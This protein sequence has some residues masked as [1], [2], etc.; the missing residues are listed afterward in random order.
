M[1]NFFKISIVSIFVIT[2]LLLS[3]VSYAAVVELDDFNLSVD[4]LLGFNDIHI[5]DSWDVVEKNCENIDPPVEEEDMKMGWLDC[6]GR[7]S[8]IMLKNNEIILIWFSIGFLDKDQLQKLLSTMSSVHNDFNIQK[9][10]D[11][12]Y[13]LKNGQIIIQ[14]YDGDFMLAYTEEQLAEEVLGFWESD[15][16]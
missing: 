4:K 5:G 6:Y 3:K 7:Y 14:D 10:D 1:K 15:N 12:T 13:V 9:P 11:Y 2:L 8:Q 16:F